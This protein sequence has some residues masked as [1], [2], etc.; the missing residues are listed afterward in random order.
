ME[1]RKI[2]SLCF[3]LA[4]LQDEP[5]RV[6]A[7][8]GEHKDKGKACIHSTGGAANCGDTVKHVSVVFC[9]CRHQ[10]ILQ[11]TKQPVVSG[12]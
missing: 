5:E 11:T 2:E 1:A 4:G 10:F 6:S 9:H 3:M 8:G 7:I 12:A